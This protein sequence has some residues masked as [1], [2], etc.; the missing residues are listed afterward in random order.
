MKARG[1]IFG[2]VLAGATA[3]LAA[4]AQTPAAAI[5]ASRDAAWTRAFASATLSSSVTDSVGREN[6]L[7]WDPRFKSLL[8]AS[9]PQKQSI[10]FEQ[11]KLISLPEM[12]QK[13]IG[14]PGEVLLDDSRYL[15]LD[16]CVPHDC[17]D[18]G[19]LWIDSGAN[20][21]VLIFA[22][23]GMISGSDSAEKSHLWLYSSE[24]LNW[25]QIPAPFLTSLHRW[26]AT[27]GADGYRGT[28]GY[29][30]DF[31]LATIVQ[32]SGIIVDIGPDV[33]GLDAG[34]SR[35]STNRTGK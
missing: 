20:P 23:T 34:S 13:F 16:G 7:N 29:R 10:W 28:K 33:L 15:T 22:G 24:K 12:I 30:Y 32:P 2:V 27:I 5:A 11:G 3:V 35:S 9:F 1:F 31:S 18:R 17:D 14:V 21:A 25:Q 19:M 4:S 26:L 6:D 8:K